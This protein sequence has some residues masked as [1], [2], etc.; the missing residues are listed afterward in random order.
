METAICIILSIACA[1]LAAVCVN[2]KARLSALREAKA[3]AEERIA[4]ETANTD[5]RLDDARQA[6]ERQIAELKA[7]YAAQLAD[8]RQAVG[9][10]FKAIASEVL[11]ANSDQLSQQNRASVEAVLAPIRTKFDEFSKGFRECYAT[12]SHE[13]LSVREELKRLHELSVQVG[14]EASRLTNALKGNAGFQGRWGEMVLLNILEH[15]G[16]EAGTWLVMQETSS[17]EEGNEIRPDAVI[18]CPGDRDIIIDSKTSLKAYFASLEATT[19]EERQS[20]MKQHIRSV[21]RHIRSLR[22]KNYQQK[23][24]VR[25]GDFVFMFMPHEGAFLAAMH[26]KPDLWQE[27]YDSRVVIASPAHLVTVLQLVE[28]LW[29]TEKQ[30]VNSQ[31]IARQG[32]QLLDSIN[33]FMADLEQVG[34]ALGKAQKT[35]DSAIHRLTTGNNNVM[36][37][38]T[39]LEELGVSSK[40]RRP[41]FC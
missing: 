32:T 23:A 8:E 37:V 27:A 29:K 28:Q 5:R 18:H 24:G 41:L 38:A 12:E 3:A 25:A 9:E 15:S 4:A 10:R 19:D 6:H 13:R 1:A 22:D 33:A 11:Q 14:A 2:Q 36:R 21:E 39:R 31:E 16:L 20:H 35:Y 30:N 34:T 40:K 17:D 26:G 7:M